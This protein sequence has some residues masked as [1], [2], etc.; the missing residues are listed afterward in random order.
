MSDGKI[1][2]D[3]DVNDEGVESKVKNTNSKIESAANTGSSAFS[4]VWTGALR[5]VGA[6]LVELGQQAVQ[7]AV[8]VGKEALAQVASFEQ[9]EGGVEKLFGDSADAVKKNANEAFRTAGMSANEYMETV[10]GFSASLI[11]SLEGDTSTAANMA[12]IAITNMSDN[13]N[14]FGTDI[15]S[16]QNAYAGFA[17]GNFTMLD[18]L[19][20]GYGGTKEEMD[21]LM[22]HAEELGGYIEGS[23]S[24]DN[25]A[26]IIEAIDII[27]T[28][29]KI[30]GLTAQTAA[31]MV[32]AGALTEEEAY[33]RLG[34]TAKEASKTIE[35]S[36]NSM[37][38][39][40]DNFLTGTMTGDEFAEVALT[41]ADNVVTA[42]MDIIPRLVE[43]FASMAPTLWD[44]GVE[45]ITNLATTISSHVPEFVEQGT[46]FIRSIPPML[47]VIPPWL[48][49]PAAPPAISWL[50]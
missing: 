9:L 3:V 32:A 37:K 20:L 23:L 27:Q 41:A 49:I 50:P 21:K 15:A 7:A 4:E 1:V 43:G 5:T 42:L 12:N 10:T 22:R 24:K 31:E 33:E 47:P 44:K 17:K 39:A 14:T 18:N 36:V 19:K 8:D 2:Y 30:S 28:D 16:I 25:F 35:G 11:S 6:K 26:D 48:P 38:A 34:T 40:W 45:I 46:A 13:A 29:M